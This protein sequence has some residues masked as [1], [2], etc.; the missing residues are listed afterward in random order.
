MNTPLNL[1]IICLKSYRLNL[2]MCR[3]RTKKPVLCGG[4]SFIYT[5]L[6]C[7]K[8]F[9]L[10]TEYPDKVRRQRLRRTVILL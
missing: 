4:F 10:Q 1:L 7:R 6:T 9:E 2:R 3:G 8:R 5:F